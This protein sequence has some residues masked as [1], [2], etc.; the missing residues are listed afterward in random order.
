MP[1]PSTVPDVPSKDARKERAPRLV[2]GVPSVQEGRLPVASHP[3]QSCPGACKTPQRRAR[4]WLWALI[5]L[6]AEATKVTA[7]L[8]TVGEV[9]IRHL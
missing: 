8:A 6:L 4:A 1:P 7:A 2:H 5:R 3:S 9:A